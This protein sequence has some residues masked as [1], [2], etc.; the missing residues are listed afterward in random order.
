VCGT[1][2]ALLFST[3][4]LDQSRAVQLVPAVPETPVPDGWTE[5][6][7]V[8]DCFNARIIGHK[9][10]VA[11]SVPLSPSVPSSLP[12]SLDKLSLNFTP[13][14]Y[15]HFSASSL[16]DFMIGMVINLVHARSFSRSLRWEYFT[17]IFLILASCF[18]WSLSFWSLSLIFESPLQVFKWVSTSADK[19][20]ELISFYKGIDLGLFR[21]SHR[22]FY[23]ADI[24]YKM[25][26]GSEKDGMS[27]QSF[28]EAKVMEWEAYGRGVIAAGRAP[29]ACLKDES[30]PSRPDFTKAYH[31][32]ND[33]QVRSQ[34][35]GF[36]FP[37]ISNV[38]LRLFPC[39]VISFPSITNS[40]L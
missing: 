31:T 4:L 8:E 6:T 11:A 14:I 21:A 37:M 27:A 24:L 15:L 10:A 34:S 40:C 23:D 35:K 26:R 29:V 1:H 25:T 17:V 5:W 20:D 36:D 33:C 30:F 32:F 12:F 19:T 39:L 22:D 13:L 9:F 16:L 28:H 38:C 18:S 2:F 3:V 7:L